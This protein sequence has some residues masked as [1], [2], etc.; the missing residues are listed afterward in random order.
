MINFKITSLVDGNLT[1]EKAQGKSVL[2]T[3]GETI[4]AEVI[5]V[6][7]SGNAVLR[8]KGELITAKTEVPLQQGEAAFFKVSDSASSASELK[9]QFIGY[10][11]SSG[12]ASV[13]TNF[14][15]TPEGKTLAGLIQELSDSLL[16]Q[17]SNQSLASTLAED[18]GSPA[19][20]G[21]ADSFPLD[22][23]ES[24]LKALP[25]DINALPKEIKTQLQ[26]LLQSS[27]RSTGQSIQLRL[28]TVLSQLSD[29]LGNSGAAGNFKSDIMLNM[30][31]L[32]SGPLKN[33]LLN[34]GVVLEAKLKSTAISMLLNAA[35]ADN[36]TAGPA[37]GTDL[38]QAA[39]PFGKGLTT[40]QTDAEAPKDAEPGQGQP[41]HLPAPGNDLK[42]VLLELKQRLSALLEN[43][44][45]A[46]VS[47]TLAAAKETAQDVAA[48]RN[49]QGKIEGLLKDVETF[50]ALSKTT[51]SFYTFLPVTWKEL[52]DGDLAFKRGREGSTGG[53]TSSC[54][55]NLSLDG[56][57]SLSILVL[58]NNRDFFVSFKA[59][60]PASHSLINSNL[61]ELKSSF[62]EKGLSLK[63][64]HMLDKTDT[65]MDKLDNLGSSGSIISIKT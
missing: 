53:A 63:A 55:I 48:L 28:E 18:G 60:K 61:A 46:Q 54:R 8:I 33:A 31:K 50:Q 57:G 26:D 12:D 21:G 22:K 10:E 52:K 20:R 38:Q 6:L 62:A 34:S 65:T 9:L 49:M 40:A 37:A 45:A 36:E 56:F 15:N 13:L 7:P 58:M 59:D 39:T 3:P 16:K 35:D 64:A 24:L 1:I 23:I 30:E 51:D 41:S 11:D 32:L 2:L 4:K 42:A 29:T 47:K 27:L 44:P 17:S 5:N 25:A 14:M 43:S 19:E